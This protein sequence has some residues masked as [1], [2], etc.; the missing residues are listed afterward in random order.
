MMPNRHRLFLLFSLVLSLLLLA[1]CGGETPAPTPPP[2][3]LPTATP[4]P[5]TAT[6]PP[7]NTPEPSPTPT[8]VPA[9]ISG[10]VLWGEGPVAGAVVELRAPD[11]RVTGDETA[12][13]RVTAGAAGQFLLAAVAPGEYSVVAVWPDGTPSAGGTP[14]VVLEPGQSVHDLTLRLE[15]PLTLL[16]PD[17]GQPVP[18][19]PTIRWEPLDDLDTYRVWIIDRGTTELLVDEVVSG[20]RLDVI[21]QLATGTDYTLVVSALGPGDEPLASATADFTTDAVA[22]PP[23]AVLL[24]AV[25][26]QP[27]LPTFLDQAAGYCF[28]YPNDHRLTGIDTL[29]Q[30]AGPT[31]GSGSE[32]FPGL[33]LAAYPLD[34]RELAEYVD[35]Y[36]AGLGDAAAA[37]ERVPTT[38]AGRPAEILEPAPGELNARLVLVAN[39]RTVHALGFTPTFRDIPTA[40]QDFL[41]R[42]AQIASD[43]L[44]ETVLATLAFLPRPGEAAEGAVELP[45]ACLRDGHSL[46][47]N[48]AVGPPADDTADE[49]APPPVGLCLAVPSG[50]TAQ[51][52]PQ[53]LPRLLGPALDA[54]LSPVRATFALEP[55]Q[56]A[57]GRSLDEVVA[58]SLDERGEDEATLTET[59]IGGE[60][61]LLVEGLTG[62]RGSQEAFFIRDGQVYQLVFQPSPAEVEAATADMARLM[63]AVLESL[64]FL[65]GAEE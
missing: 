63:T 60:A 17:T 50:F 45:A 30:I 37:V 47:I 39:G 33:S 31:V 46:F 15:R 51:R 22:T 16:E 35:D 57:D 28:A 14:A 52:T 12:A 59:T 44:F 61:A 54:S 56:P 41:Q 11:W 42:R 40:E 32:L 7:T 48:A 21:D 8:A 34:G 29:P 55:P 27:G 13:G 1:A 19:L 3:A 24:P 6:P 10:R 26:A 2:T 18:T 25:C 65:G 4:P 53:G 9:S 20:D 58:A 5:P 49:D 36:L 23:R 43:A 64:S 62:G 38:I